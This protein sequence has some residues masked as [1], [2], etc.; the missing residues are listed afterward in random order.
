MRTKARRRGTSHHIAAI[1]DAFT[2]ASGEDV[3]AVSIPR[4]DRRFKPRFKVLCAGKPG[5][6]GPPLRAL[7]HLLEKK[8]RRRRLNQ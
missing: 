7:L 6:A 4:K 3:Y 5:P 1:L 8:G 2:R